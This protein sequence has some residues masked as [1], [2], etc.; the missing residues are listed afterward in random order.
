MHQSEAQHAKLEDALQRMQRALD[1]A[2]RRRAQLRKELQE[3]VAAGSSDAAYAT[4]VQAVSGEI[5]CKCI[6]GTR[7]EQGQ[8][9]RATDHSGL[10]REEQIANGQLSEFDVLPHQTAK[11]EAHTKCVR[12]QEAAA[13]G[14]FLAAV[15]EDSI[16]A[17]QVTPPTLQRCA[18]GRGDCHR[19][20]LLRQCDQGA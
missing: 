12:N 8:A 3:A 2:A 5:V 19:L 10:Q 7:D 14:D 16:M 4:L 18:C 20:R 13:W 15:S 6:W 1:L 17:R 9:Q 11:A